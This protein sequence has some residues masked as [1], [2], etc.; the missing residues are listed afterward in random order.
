M[1]PRELNR[2]KRKKSTCYETNYIGLLPKRNLAPGE[3]PKQ[4]SKHRTKKDRLESSD[5]PCPPLT[6]L[7]QRNKSG[8]GRT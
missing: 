3:A 5:K 2:K 6:P 4:L 7:D 1:E 8:S